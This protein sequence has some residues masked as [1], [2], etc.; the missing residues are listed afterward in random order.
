M[1]QNEYSLDPF[2]ELSADLLCIAGFDGYFKRINP[3][4]SR[5]LEYSIEE[6][7]SNPINTFI[8]PDDVE[9]TSRYRDKIKE[10]IPLLNFENRYITKS[11]KVVWLSWTSIPLN[12]E[13][14]VY[15]IAKNVTHQK[16]LEADRAALIADLTRANHEL[17]ELSYS[18]SHDLRAPVTNLLSIHQLL[19]SSGAVDPQAQQLLGYLKKATGQ[20]Y[21]TLDDYLD[22]ISKDGIV[23][24]MVETLQIEQVLAEVLSSIESLV[25]DSGATFQV[26]LHAAPTI[27]FS[28][29]YL[30]SVLLNL[31]TNSIKYAQPGIAPV[32]R[33][34]SFKAEKH[35]VL[36]VAD[37]GLGMDM[38]KVGN[39]LFG[40]HQ[41]FSDRADSKGIGLY[42][43]HNHVASMGGKIEVSSK[44]N[45]GTTF[46]ISIPAG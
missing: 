29:T 37:N 9:L 20:L 1:E 10:N 32:V 21:K 11:G 40:L 8:H 2:F 31:I 5:L 27:R 44:L 13:Q 35:L 33:V 38:E 17:K 39:K 42:L 4:V 45:E 25:R 28:K 14:L 36:E 19:D 24:V 43:V 16:R 23:K 12:S 34:R 30:E 15:A 22:T 6:L 3:A 7:M 26:D 18:T 41:K 46:K